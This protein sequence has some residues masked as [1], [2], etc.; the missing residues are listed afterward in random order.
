MCKGC[1]ATRIRLHDKGVHFPTQ[2]VSCVSPHEDTAHL[3]F[4][5]PFAIQVCCQSRLWSQIHYTSLVVASAVDTIF[6]LIE[7]L[8]AEQKQLFAAIL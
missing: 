2:C 3:F 6:A 1:L 4:A 5:F 7:A 8:P